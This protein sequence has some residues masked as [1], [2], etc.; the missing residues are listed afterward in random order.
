MC[1]HILP[2]VYQV[3]LQIWVILGQSIEGTLLTQ[4]WGQRDACGINI[5]CYILKSPL[6]LLL[7]QNS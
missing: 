4:P 7:G 1:A 6:S 5:I 2:A 3:G